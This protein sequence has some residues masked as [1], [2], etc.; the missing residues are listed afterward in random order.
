M[1][2]TYYIKR[3]ILWFVED[4]RIHRRLCTVSHPPRRDFGACRPPKGGSEKR[5]IW[6]K[7]SVW[8]T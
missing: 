1:H 4:L 8:T 5:G 7:G 2:Y 6:G 3:C